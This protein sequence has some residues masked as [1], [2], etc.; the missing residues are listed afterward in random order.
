MLNTAVNLALRIIR[1]A[2][3]YSDGDELSVVNFIKELSACHGQRHGLASTHVVTEV[4]H[5]GPSQY[6]DR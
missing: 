6:I 2:F 1:T 5:H 3:L 4:K